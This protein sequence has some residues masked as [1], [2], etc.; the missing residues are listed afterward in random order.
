MG[1]GWRLRALHWPGGAARCVRSHIPGALSILKGAVPDRARGLGHTAPTYF[2]GNPGST[3]QRPSRLRTSNSFRPFDGSSTSGSID[4]RQGRHPP[5]SARAPRCAAGAPLR[6][7]AAA[8][9]RR[10]RAHSARGRAGRDRLRLHADE[11]RDQS[12]SADAQ[13]RGCRR[14]L[15]LPAVAGRGQPLTMRA[16][17]SVSRWCRG[18][19]ASANRG[20]MRPRSFPISSSCRCWP[21]T[22]TAIASA[23]ARAT[24]T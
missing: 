9:D 4:R 2:V 15:A 6:A 7:A 14:A 21:S 10:A 1:G 17:R 5:R 19:G 22:A 18:S 16:F 3:L 12:R 20:L 8:G 24:T 13:A 23:M 11:E